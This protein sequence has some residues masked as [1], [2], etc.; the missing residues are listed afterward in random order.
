MVV[1][2]I[3]NQCGPSYGTLTYPRN[4]HIF[5]QASGRDQQKSNAMSRGFSS[6]T[7]LPGLPAVAGYQ[8]RDK[9]PRDPWRHRTKHAR[10]YRQAGIGGLL[11]QLSRSFAGASVGELLECF[12][13]SGHGETAQPWVGTGPNKP[14]TRP[15]SNRPSAPR[16]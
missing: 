14:I 11:G 8:N 4:T 7:A 10:K 16:W 3:T 9:A 6:M 2:S 12:N 5:L 15:S 1:Q 13:Q